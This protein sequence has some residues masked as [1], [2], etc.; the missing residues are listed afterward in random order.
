MKQKDQRFTLDNLRGKRHYDAEADPEQHWEVVTSVDT[1]ADAQ[2]LTNRLAAADFPV[3]HTEIIGRGLELVERVTGRLTTGRA[4]AAGAGSGAWVG[5]FV[6][7]LVGLFT[8]G[9]AWIG[10]VLGGVLIGAVWGALFGLAA[11]WVTRD[12][13]YMS[14]QTLTADRYDIAVTPEYADLAR[15]LIGRSVA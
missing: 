5:L 10:L 14:V 1:Y 3:A 12:R 4:V 8:R 15:R 2:R 11:Q 7:L 9:P 13:D 6:G